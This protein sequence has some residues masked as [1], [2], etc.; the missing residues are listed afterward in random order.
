MENQSNIINVNT[1]KAGNYQVNL[2]IAKANTPFK[3][4]KDFYTWVNYM[5]AVKYLKE[6]GLTLILNKG[7]LSRGT[8]GVV[9][10]LTKRRFAI[11]ING[12]IRTYVYYKYY[13]TRTYQLNPQNSSSPIGYSS[14]RVTFPKEYNYM[15]ILLWKSIQ[16]IRKNN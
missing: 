14:S 11:T 15:A 5:A 12:Y 2:Q 13:G 16:R 3:E 6:K 7:N 1:L 9:D 4:D 8:I 10:P